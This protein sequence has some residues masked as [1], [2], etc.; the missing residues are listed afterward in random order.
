MSELSQEEI[1]RRR[2]ARLTASNNSPSSTSVSPLATPISQS[3]MSTTQDQSPPIFESQPGSLEN[4]FFA[5][6]NGTV[7]AQKKDNSKGAEKVIEG[8]FKEPSKPIDIQMPSSSKQRSRAPPVRSDSETSSIHMEVDEASGSADKI[9]ANTDIDSGFENMEVDESDLFKKDIHRQRTTSSSTELTVEQLQNTVARILQSSFTENSSSGVFLPQTAELI[10]ETPHAS[11]RDITSTAI[12]EI[13][14]IIQKDN[15]SFKNITSQNPDITDTYSLHSGSVSPIQSS[16]STSDTQ[17]PVPALIMKEKIDDRSPMTLAIKFLMESYN[18]VAQEERNFPKKSS[19]PPLSDVLTEVRAQLIQYTALVVK[20]KEDGY[21]KSPLLEPIVHQTIPRGFLTELVTR[22]HTNEILFSEVFSPILQGLFR[23]MRTADFSQN[24]TDEH[25]CHYRL[26]LQALYE[27]AEIRCNSRPICTLITKQFQ[28]H[29]SEALT[30][31]SGR[32][33]TVLSFLGPF[34]DISVFAED[35]PKMAEK[36]TF[37]KTANEKILKQCLQQEFEQVRHILHKIFHFILA[38]QDSRDICLKYLAQILK[39]NEKRAQIAMEG[40]LVA[41]DGFM[42]NVLT[43]LQNLSVKINFNKMDLMYPFHPQAMIQIQND[44]RLKFSSQEVGDWLE[45]F[46]KTHE[47]PNPNFSTICWFL[48]L[49]C[50]HLSLLPTIQKYQRTL[51]TIRDLQKLLDETIA[52][53]AQWKNTPYAIR[54][55]QFIKKSKQQLKKL[56]RAKGCA[57]AGLLDPNVMRRSLLFYTTVCDYL[58]SLMTGAPP[59]TPVSDLPLPPPQSPA[60]YAMPEWYVEDIAEFLLFALQY[61][62]NLIT[63]NAEDTLITWLLVTICSSNMFKNPY[64]VAKLIEVVFVIIPNIQPRCEPLYNRLMSHPISQTVLSS[65]LMKF[66]TD[67]ETT[68]TSSEFYDKFS[69]RYH[70]SLIIKGMWGSPIHRKAVMDESKTGTQFVK[71]IN[72]LMND[73]TFLLDESLESLKRIH[74]I[75]ELIADDKKWSKLTTDQQTSRMRQLSADERQCRSYLTLA[76]ETVD[77]FHYLTVHIKEPFL[78]PELAG[79]LASMLNFNLQQL[80]GKKYKDLKVENPDKYGWEPRRLLSSLVDIYLHLDCDTFAEALA[81]DERSFSR[82]LFSDAASLMERVGIKTTVE[83]EQFRELAEKACRV[84]ERNQK[85][86][87]WLEDA[88]DEFKDPLM[89]TLM[90]DPVLLPSGQIMDRSVIMRHLLN[91]N[92]DP[93]NRQPLT[94]DMLLPVEDLKERIRIWKSEKSKT[95]HLN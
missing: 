26:P 40:R 19:I 35:N 90:T 66:Y 80:C 15:N 74:E 1:R 79:R 68:G 88:P 89:D 25:K 83:T 95:T 52:A 67:V 39:S 47:F 14:T 24:E 28:F 73:T 29:M 13:L 22:T 42:L 23:L 9:S 86:D 56:N 64:L 72:M 55:K 87:A 50:H 17:C 8:V 51:R 41:G 38:N 49:H 44:T 91:S 85:S 62:P 12:M 7:Q 93:F 58:L 30:S 37:G 3:P 32:E 61:F 84:V 77:M 78:R 48:T 76:R 5:P 31:A 16:P 46:G 43:V 94:E 45:E 60:F 92:T 18:R 27:L 10:K 69:I 82:Q 36:L 53:E 75:Q 70:I 71:F 81:S 20:R 54:N 2:L 11:I 33:L 59:G 65:C 6:T 34:L 21:G 57:D 4:K 63:D